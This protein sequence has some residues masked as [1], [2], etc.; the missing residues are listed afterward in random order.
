[1]SATV[2]Y[3]SIEAVVALHFLGNM[4]DNN[5]NFVL[6]PCVLGGLCDGR[7]P[8]TEPPVV[9]GAPPV[10]MVVRNWLISVDGAPD[11]VGLH[12]ATY[13]DA[14]GRNAYQDTVV[15]VFFSRPVRGVDNRSFILTDSHGIQ[16]PAWVDQ[17][18]DGAWG[19]FPNSVTLKA[20]E[21]YTARLK[22]GICGLAHDCTTHDTVWQFSVSKD[23]GQGTG[24]TSIPMG[25]TVPTIHGNTLAATGKRTPTRGTKQTASREA[26][27]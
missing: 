26:R 3:Q 27:E 20:G 4:A 17:I 23:A 12:M 8:A 14:G 16:V 7:K 24:D 13:P 22:S 1:V 15:K 25:F 11:A 21:S 18:G 9:E 10:P 2:Y 19:L 6:E 5:G